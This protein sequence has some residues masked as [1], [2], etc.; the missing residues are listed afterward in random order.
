MRVYNKANLRERR[1]IAMDVR[2]LQKAKAV[3]VK[4]DHTVIVNTGVC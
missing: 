2:E 1:T 4:Q 3:N